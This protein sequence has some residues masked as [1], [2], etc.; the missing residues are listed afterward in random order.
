MG[1]LLLGNQHTSIAQVRYRGGHLLFASPCM[2]GKRSKRLTLNV[3]YLTVH[4]I[5][6]QPKTPTHVGQKRLV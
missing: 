3:V 4:E 5:D 6:V 1:Y 2:Y